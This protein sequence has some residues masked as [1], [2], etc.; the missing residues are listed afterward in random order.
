MPNNFIRE[1]ELFDVWGI[2][3]LGPF[4]PSNV[5]N[6]ILLLVDYVSKWIEEIFRHFLKHNIFFHFGTPCALIN[7]EGIHFINKQMEKLLAK[8][9]VKNMVAAAHHPQSNGQA[10]VSNL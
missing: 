4:P 9:I 2:D 7:D 8:Y 6:Y 10:K 5:N 1:V 3:F